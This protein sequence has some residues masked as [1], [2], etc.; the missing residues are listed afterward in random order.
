MANISIK[1]NLRQFKHVFKKMKGKD[2]NEIDVLIIPVEANN[3]F[4]GEKGVYADLTAIE[5]KNKV[6]DN[7][8][9]HLIK[10]NLP[11]EVYNAMTDEEKK[12]T[13]IMGNAILWSRQ[14]PEPQ[15]YDSEQFEGSIEG[16]DDD[17]PF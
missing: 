16:P 15:Q 12:S 1:I 4:L 10:Q 11:K 9:T 8:D 5:I 14:E 7:K 2:G 13:P 6:G 17:L 3:L